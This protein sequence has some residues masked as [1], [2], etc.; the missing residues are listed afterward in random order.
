MSYKDNS[1]RGQ[2]GQK[3]EVTRRAGLIFFGEGNKG[4]N[5]LTQLGEVSSGILLLHSA[6]K[7][8]AGVEMERIKTW[9]SL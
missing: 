6:W 4:R 5:V 8:A 9:T 2:L 7:S 3:A 1:E